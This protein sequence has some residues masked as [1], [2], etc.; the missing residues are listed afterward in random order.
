ML[1]KKEEKNKEEELETPERGVCWKQKNHFQTNYVTFSFI[2][3]TFLKLNQF[4]LH[5]ATDVSFGLTQSVSL[6]PELDHSIQT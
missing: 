4:F 3:K 5:Q 1:P 6:P 2:V